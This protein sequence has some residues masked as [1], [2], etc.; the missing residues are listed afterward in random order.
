[1][2]HSFNC[3]QARLGRRG[4]KIL[5]WSFSLRP[6]LRL[7]LCNCIQIIDLTL[8][9]VG[10]ISKFLIAFHIIIFLLKS[11]IFPVQLFR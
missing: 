1:M 10:E 2:V 8:L 5:G 4:A 11:L 3:F 7:K 6:V 9:L